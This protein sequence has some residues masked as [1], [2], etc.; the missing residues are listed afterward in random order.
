MLISHQHRLR[1]PDAASMTAVPRP[2]RLVVTAWVTPDTYTAPA[3]D[4]AS[5]TVPTLPLKT[6]FPVLPKPHIM[7][8]QASLS[9]ST[10]ADQQWA[11]TAP[12]LF[13]VKVL[14]EFC[15]QMVRQDSGSLFKCRLRGHPGSAAGLGAPGCFSRGGGQ[16][17][18][19]Q[20]PEFWRVALGVVMPVMVS[21]ETPG[22]LPVKDPGT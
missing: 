11:A 18:P 7:V 20:H 5:A 17:R 16:E 15:C 10:C 8:W 19:G 14:L 22:L 1:L 6:R 12:I 21:P 9:Q 4:D 2:S 3:P 13:S